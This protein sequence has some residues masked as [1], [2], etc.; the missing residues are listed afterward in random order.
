MQLLKAQL[1]AVPWDFLAAW[2][3]EVVR[4]LSTLSQPDQLEFELGQIRLE[5]AAKI[6]EVLA[7]KPGGAT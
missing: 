3:P 4:A 6:A 5:I 2:L 7:A 1:P